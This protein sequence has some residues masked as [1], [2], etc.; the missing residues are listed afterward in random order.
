VP[1]SDARLFCKN[2]QV[3]LKNKPK[4]GNLTKKEYHQISALPGNFNE[5]KTSK[6]IK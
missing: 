6:K 5:T 3:N 2:K 4:I 1:D